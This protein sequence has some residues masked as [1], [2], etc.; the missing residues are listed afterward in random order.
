M[1]IKAIEK[2]DAEALCKREESHFYD[3]KSKDV[4]PAKIEKVCVAFANSDGGEVVIGIDDNVDP[5]NPTKA[6]SGRKDPEEYNSIIQSL[7]NLSPTVSVT[8]ELLT[9]SALNGLV[10]YINVDKSKSVHKTSDNTVYVREGAQSIPIKDPDKI[11]NLSYAKGVSSF[12]EEQVTNLK[13]E[14]VVETEGLNSFLAD[15]SPKSEPLEYLL[16]EYL[17]DT[18][19][20]IP[21]YSSVLLFHK[22]PA[23]ALPKR[24]AVKIIRYETKEDDPERDH[25]KETFTIEGPLYKL[26]H[27]SVEKVTSILSSVKIWT[28]NGLETV[29]YPPETL[30]EILVNAIIHR[31][32]SISDDVQI[33]IYDNRVEVKSPGKLPSMITSEN[34]LNERFSRN[35]KIVRN[36]NRYKNPPNKDIGEG[37]NTAFQKMKDW[38]LRQPQIQE[39]GNYV[40]VTI[41]H[42]S[43][44]RP[45][46][47]VLEFLSKNS[48][49]TNRQARDLTG[50]RS[51]NEMK[52][53]FYKLKDDNKIEKVPDKGGS[54]SAWRLVK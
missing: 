54:A 37:L 18:H 11:R 3:R 13:A 42:V 14:D 7:F 21:K 39:S 50:I 22:N 4:L 41:P 23:A 20:W 12:E 47:T 15:F 27:V 52:S 51:E 48:E 19:S 43:L 36:L 1:K 44:A 2:K 5:N 53:V 38:K 10:L 33:L 30:W 35:P 6:W 9:A 32:Y 16:N 8:Y 31:D 40:I 34:I 17:L 24:C 45:E 49:I 26:I 46:E 25:L 29:K 28:V